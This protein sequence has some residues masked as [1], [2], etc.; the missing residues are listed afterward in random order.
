M[1]APSHTLPRR[2]RWARP[3]SGSDVLFWVSAVVLAGVIVVAVAAPALAPYD[4]EA[5]DLRASLSGPS[6]EH[7]LGTD[8][9]GRDVLSRTLTGARLSLLAPAFILAIASTIGP[10]LG[11]LAAWRGGWADALVSRATDV[12]YAFPGLLFAV[13]AIAVLGPGVV[14]A[15]VAL[16]LAYFPT[17]AKLTRSVALSEKERDYVAAYR[18]Q[19]MGG[20]RL[21][22]T[23]LLP[24]IAPVIIGYVVV[25]FGEALISLAS[26]SFLG[27]G[28]QPPASDWGL[29]VSSGQL[30][31]L[32][33]AF[34]PSLVPGV[35]I[36]ITVVAINVV[37]VR[38][39]DRLGRVEP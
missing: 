10:V 8:Q 38:I 14:A 15:V 33:G 13:L 29:M 27:F 2:A 20:M 19:G 30:A 7:W 36:V 6:A 1:S 39:A 37:G 18:V 35:A 23:R 11:V 32:Q 28:V 31:L 34:W 9:S 25:L 3:L 22:L 12:L 5:I 17:I 26:L 21:C 4:P 24:N 16:G